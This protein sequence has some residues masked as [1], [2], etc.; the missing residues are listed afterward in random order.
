MPG[1]VHVA[2]RH[3]VAAPV[4]LALLAV[5][6][7]RAGPALGRAQHDHRPRR[8]AL[9]AA[10]ARRRPR[11]R[12][13]SAT[14]ASSVAAIAWCTV[15]GLAA[16]DEVRLV[17]V[18]LEELVQLVLRDAREEA[19][20]GDLV[21]VQVQDRQHGAVADRVE[22]LVAVPAGGQRAGLGLAV[23]DDAGDD[24]VGIVERGAEGV[25]ERVTELAA[26]VD[27]SRASPVRRGWECRPG[28][29]NCLNSRFIPSSSWLRCP[30]RPRCRCPRARRAR[31]APGRRDPGR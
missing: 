22:E 12:W 23:A 7:R 30:D 18:A 27:A 16:L 8:T 21:A 1:L 15:C 17:A 29:E 13:I 10:R 14:A 5:D 6:L 25:R 28:S 2:H 9:D 11:S 31:R 20:V 4:V 3:L 19:G 26:F 24:Q